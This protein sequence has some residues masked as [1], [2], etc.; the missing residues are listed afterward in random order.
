MTR[1]VLTDDG[2]LPGS[3]I[4]NPRCGTPTNSGGVF[5]A[6]T[7]TTTYTGQN[8]TAIPFFNP[9]F[10]SATETTTDMTPMENALLTLLDDAQTIINIALYGLNRQSVV[11]ALIAAHNRGVTVRV[12]GDDDA[13]TGDYQAA[14][15]ALVDAGITLVTDSSGAI[16]HNKFLV[17][18]GNI[19][20][21]GSTNFTDTGFT[22]NANNS[23]IITDT[24]L[25]AVYTTEFNEMWAGNFHK[26]K[27]DNTPHL[28]DY[29]GTAVEN[30]F[31]PTDLPAF[32]VWEA[33]ADTEETI[34]VAM[35]F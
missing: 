7:L 6:C 11:D 31:S 22:L 34:H 27:S 2:S 4:H 24:T 32:A 29:N 14:Y 10:I 17:I 18:D 28:F 19:L 12:V 26:D 9:H 8:L 20:W 30:Y 16:E 25:A 13:Y 35:F 5:Y 33:L 21:T 23:V 3:W 1:T 15:Q